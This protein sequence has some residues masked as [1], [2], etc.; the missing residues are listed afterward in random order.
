MAITMEQLVAKLG[1]EFLDSIH[2]A[3]REDLDAIRRFVNDIPPKAEPIQD[4]L[5]DLDTRRDMFNEFRAICQESDPY[6]EFYPP[7][8]TILAVFMVAPVSEIRVQLDVLHKMEQHRTQMVVALLGLSPHAMRTYIPRRRSANAPDY[9]P[10]SVPSA[11]LYE[12]GASVTFSLVIRSGF[13]GQVKERDGHTCVFSGMP[14]PEAAYIFPFST[15]EKKVF[16]PLNELLAA[17]WGSEKATAWRQHFEDPGVTQ[18]A[19]NG[20]S[21]NHQIHFWFDNARL[22]L[23]PLRQTPEGIFVQWHWLKRSVL[24]PNVYILQ[25]TDILH[26]AGVMDQCWG[27]A[28]AHRESGVRIQT[29]QVFLLQHNENMP[30]WDLL[31]MQW[32]LLRVAALCGAAD[33]TDDYYN[34]EDPEERGYDQAVA[35]KQRA[36]LVEF[37]KAM[38]EGTQGKTEVTDRGKGKGVDQEDAGVEVTGD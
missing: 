29:G 30:S 10:N 14:D 13:A 26:Q 38:G 1:T 23:K 17:F 18:S 33:V 5:T 22:A 7:H 37:E 15:S 20:I 2:A 6:Q 4:Y 32:D 11:I 16:G 24:K 9:P 21:L 28:L 27:K 35:A 31:E 25:G 12:P 36:L 34:S 3:T 19:K 8:A